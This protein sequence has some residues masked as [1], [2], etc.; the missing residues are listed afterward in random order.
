[1][2]K[3]N[4]FFSRC[5]RIWS[6]SKIVGDFLVYQELEMRLPYVKSYDKLD[7]KTKQRIKDEDLK[8]QI[9]AKGTFIH[10]KT[11]L[12]KKTITVK[13]NDSLQHMII[14]EDK[15]GTIHVLYLLLIIKY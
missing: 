7:K 8:V 14:Y 5:C 12:C 6:P 2:S 15:E 10:R 1:M 9:S 4:C 3:S 11:G 13:L